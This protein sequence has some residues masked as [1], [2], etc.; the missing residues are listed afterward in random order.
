[1]TEKY[2]YCEIEY[3][4]KAGMDQSRCE[5]AT[6]AECFHYSV[7]YC[8]SEEAQADVLEIE[9]PE[10]EP[11]PKSC[12]LVESRTEAI[13]LLEKIEAVSKIRW[14][15]DDDLPTQWAPDIY[16]YFLIFDGDLSY[17][18]KRPCGRLVTASEFV[19][20]CAKRMPK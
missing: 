13:E 19:Q 12:T 5:F 4:C 11:E 14:C 10:P 6:G 15:D 1:M 18:I 3:R 20:E 9:P 2:N 17:G 16:P 7:G 8:C